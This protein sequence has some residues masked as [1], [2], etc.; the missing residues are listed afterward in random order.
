MF[1]MLVAASMAVSAVAMIFGMLVKFNPTALLMSVMWV[2][3]F[4]SA[5]FSKEVSI[6]GFTEHLPPNLL[7]TAA[8]DLTVF[9]REGKCLIAVAVSAAILIIATLVGAKLFNRKGFAI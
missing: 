6:P 9:G 4:L 3:L 8:F 1:F 7:Q 5:S 2:L